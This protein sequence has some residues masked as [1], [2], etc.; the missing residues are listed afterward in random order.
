MLPSPQQHDGRGR[1][2]RLDITRRHERAIA[3]AVFRV[4]RRFSR[5][6]RRFV[7]FRV[8]HLPENV[9]GGG[10][11]GGVILR[12]RRDVVERAVGRKRIFRVPVGFDRVFVLVARGH[13]RARLDRDERGI[14]FRTRSGAGVAP[15]VAS[16][17][18]FFRDGKRWR[19]DAADV[20]RVGGVRDVLVRPFQARELIGDA[21]R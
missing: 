3:R 19:D 10:V 16:F 11:V 20:R 9:V 5:V 18:G 12:L 4:N 15:F 13:L 8:N 14:R 7:F 6:A 1:R 17:G 2:A 21:S